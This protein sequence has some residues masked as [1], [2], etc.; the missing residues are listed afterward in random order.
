MKEMLCER[1]K[2]KMTKKG[3]LN[4][5]NTKYDIWKCECGSEK[6]VALGVNR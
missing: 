1:C 3:M 5:G 6:L 4:S 2:K